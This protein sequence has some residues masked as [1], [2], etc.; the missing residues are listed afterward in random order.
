M[1]N[2]LS[3]AFNAEFWAKEMQ[4][5]YLK[6]NVGRSTIA[7]ETLSSELVSGTRIHRPYRS[8]LKVQNYTKGTAISTF[9]DLSG[10]DEY[11]DIDTTKLIAMYVD[12]IDKLENKWDMA[13]KYSGDAGKLLNNTIDQALFAQYSNAYSYVSAGDLGGSGTGSYAVGTSNISN[14]FTVAGRKL[15]KFNRG[16]QNRFAIVGPRLKE[17]LALSTGGRETGFGDKVEA[18]GF[19]GPKYGFDVY[20]SNNVPFSCTVVTSGIPTDGQVFYVDGVTFTWEAHGTACSSAGEVDI[21]TSEDEAY[22]NLVLA[23]DGTTAGTTSTY[24]DVSADDREQLTLGGIDASYTS[25]ALIIT[26]YGDVVISEGDTS[27]VTSVTTTH[28]PLFG[29]KGCLDFIVEKEPHVEFRT[30]ENLLGRKI[31]PWT[32]YGIKLF[33]KEKKSLVYGKI[34]ASSWV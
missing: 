14:L 34:D 2:D 3:T 24:C 28:Y 21:G 31:Y 5:S 16:I 33:T 22:A 9:T 20:L 32:R 30:C 27:N 17:S 15:D 12:D 18:N 25:H 11:L 4:E 13:E 7:N 8:P 1:A 10:T 6:E 19:V 23:I 29:V 26:G